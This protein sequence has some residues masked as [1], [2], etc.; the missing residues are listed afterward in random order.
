M[1]KDIFEQQYEKLLDLTLKENERLHLKEPTHPYLW[2]VN[3]LAPLW[4]LFTYGY[5]ARHTDELLDII[6]SRLPWITKKDAVTSLKREFSVVRQDLASRPE[7][8]KGSAPKYDAI[9]TPEQAAAY[10]EH[11]LALEADID[12]EDSRRASY[13][14]AERARSAET[15]SASAGAFTLDIGPEIYEGV[16]ELLKDY[17]IV[18]GVTGAAAD[19][20]LAHVIR[21]GQLPRECQGEKLEFRR[22]RGSMG[23]AYYFA[24]VLFGY[25]GDPFKTF[26][27]CFNTD[28]ADGV[29][30][31][32]RGSSTE[33]EVL[34]DETVR[35]VVRACRDAFL[36]SEN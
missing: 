20:R 22:G 14:A 35:G 23:S 3:T 25:R 7:S 32:S 30:A 34:S 6:D 19:R 29:R 13:E 33:P 27:K 4:A 28:S 11:L 12:R 10:W 36:A 2:D 31:S 26:N 1:L 18:P 24:Q 5:D 15:S 21:F 8:Q 17:I 16:A 9:L